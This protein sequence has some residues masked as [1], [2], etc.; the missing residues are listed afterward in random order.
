MFEHF[1]LT[2]I[3]M[4]FIASTTT[5]GGLW[6][7]FN[8]RGA[9]AAMGL[10]QRFS[11]SKEA[12]TVFTLCSGRTTALGLILFALYFQNKFAEVDT[13]MTI[14][15]SYVGFVDGYAFWREG[16]RRKAVERA[17]SGFAVAAWGW[18]GM[19]GGR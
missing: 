6:P 14:L 8:V 12:R 17:L 3:P 9:T 1:R 5:F 18:F 11:D 10:P 7:F 2:H 15:G 4:L 19:V 16:L 13:V